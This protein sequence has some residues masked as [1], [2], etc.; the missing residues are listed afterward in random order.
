MK[1]LTLV[2]PTTVTKENDLLRRIH[3]EVESRG[4]SILVALNS[5]HD[6]EMEIESQTEGEDI[7]EQ[8]IFNL[9][10]A[11]GELIARYQPPIVHL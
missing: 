11:V 2:L 1:K 8:L 4:Y 6:Y 3:N 10:L 7:T 5:S 9:G